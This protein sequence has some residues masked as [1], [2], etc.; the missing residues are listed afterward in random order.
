MATEGYIIQGSFTS[1]GSAVPY[2]LQLP[3]QTVQTNV[4]NTNIATTLSQPSL[5]SFKMYNYTKYGTNDQTIEMKWFRGMGDGDAL[6]ITRGTTDLS[7][8]LETTN[9]FTIINNT[10]LFG[11]QITAI[12]KANPGVATFVGPGF[13]PGQGIPNWASGDTFKFS[14][15]GGSSGT[16]WAALNGN[17]YT[18]TR[19]SANTFSFAVDTS[20]YTG[21]YTANS[22]VA[23]RVQAVSGQ[24][25]PPLNVADVGIGLGSAVLGN[26]GDVM[27]WEAL[28]S[29]DSRALGDIGA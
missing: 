27:Y 7:S 19:I 12:T 21:T 13:S 28:I 8:S 6:L 29:D 10:D 26:D 1:G 15:V 14:F 20:G 17:S 4:S 25:I 22:G 24:P 18:I 2:H 23:Y 3:I 16:D 11:V 5:V 9:G